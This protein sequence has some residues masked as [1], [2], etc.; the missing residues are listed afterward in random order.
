MAKERTWP[1][2]PAIRMFWET[3]EKTSRRTFALIVAVKREIYISEKF[4]INSLA[5][6]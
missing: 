2:A 3:A 4:A 5:V 6:N 1:L